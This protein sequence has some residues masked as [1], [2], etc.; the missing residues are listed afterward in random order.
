MRT[1]KHPVLNIRVREDGGIVPPSGVLTYGYLSGNGYRRFDIHR[2]A[3]RV[4]R[5]VAETF[6]QF[7]I[8]DGMQVD[9]INRDKSDN[10]LANL[11]LVTPSVN[12]KNRP[13]YDRCGAEL[14]VHACDDPKGY[15]HAYYEHT[16]GR[17]QAAYR[18]STKGKEA[19]RRMNEKF[20]ESHTYVRLADGTR[21]WFPNDIAKVLIPLP[22]KKR[23]L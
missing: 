21:R 6:I 15:H 5:L 23:I 1:R 17:A 19:T 11:R 10:R 3:Y 16:K 20:R 22:V 4:H 2:K 14:G 12:C 7:P 13:S 8:P 9:H 18:R